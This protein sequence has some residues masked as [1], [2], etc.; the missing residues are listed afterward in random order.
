[1]FVGD[2]LFIF[3]CLLILILGILI[4]VA[5]LVIL[6][7]KLLG[8]IQD[9]KGPNKVII[10]GIFQ[11]FRDAIKLFVKEYIILIK[12]NILIYFISPIVGFF[13]SLILM[14][15]LPLRENLFS[16]NIFLLYIMRCLSIGVYIIIIRG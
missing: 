1:M 13:I 15:G 3:L 6:E 4:G 9:R 14:M 11:P 16:I 2:L 10:L 12:I 5:F 8:Y 7:R